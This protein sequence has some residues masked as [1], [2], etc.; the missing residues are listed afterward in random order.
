MSRKS[1]RNKRAKALAELR[2]LGMTD[3]E[4]EKALGHP[5]KDDV[6]DAEVV[7]LP[8]E[9]DDVPSITGPMNNSEVG[10]IPAISLP[11][12]IP[13]L[14]P[15]RWSEEWW[16][17]A[18]PEVKARRCKAHK[19]TGERCLKAAIDGATVCRV[20]GG[21][22]RHV[23]AAARARLDNAAD[24]MAKE[25]LG[26]A[27][28]AASESVKLAAVRDALDR[29]GLAKPTRVEL[30]P[31]DPKPYE[32]IMFDAITTET[33]AESRA[34]RGLADDARSAGLA[35]GEETPSGTSA[36]AGDM[37]SGAQSSNPPTEG[38][39]HQAGGPTSVGR[40]DQHTPA[41]Q[42]VRAHRPP[43]SEFAF[44]DP[45]SGELMTEDEGA[46]Y[47]ARLA[48]ERAEAMPV[49]HPE[50]PHRRYTAHRRRSI[51]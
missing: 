13:V 32:E 42:G 49:R 45:V 14:A 5:I 25:L 27:T 28:G 48:N 23:K 7:E 30:G 19:K 1:I 51:Y 43:R 6:I 9:S 33:R 34:R 41:D 17:Q 15:P 26:I 31:L 40:T 12:V 11:A 39:S 3:A 21:A 18:S 50:S 22:A 2:E 29:A 4:I 35:R 38:D 16:D 46:L 44:P 8:D 24:L 36:Y 20:H 47:L 10:Q 37:N